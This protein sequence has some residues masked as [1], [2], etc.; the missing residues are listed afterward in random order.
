MNR[1]HP[2]SSAALS[3]TAALFLAGCGSGGDDTGKE[4]PAAGATASRA[5]ASSSSDPAPKMSLP[6][7]L[8]ATFEDAEV[9]GDEAA[10][11]RDAENYARAILHGIAAQ[12]P[13]AAPVHHYSVPGSKAE[14]YA[15]FQ[16]E[17]HAE[18]GFTLT[19]ERT[20]SRATAE[21]KAGGV[22][23]TFC[24][25]ETRIRGRSEEG[26]P[27]TFYEPGDPKNLWFWTIDMVNSEKD[28]KL[29][30]AKNTEVES[31]ATEQCG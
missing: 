21:P 27:I 1:R 8:K 24:S 11:L 4:P 7:D 15:E 31:G 6:A 30:R 16:I 5:P 18:A 14:E 17:K 25:D 28:E 2:L 9:S 19:G 3:L 23:V 12:D 22:V 26:E 20:H 13:K 10:A 29:W